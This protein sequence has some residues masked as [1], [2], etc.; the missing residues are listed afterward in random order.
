MSTTHLPEQYTN[1]AHEAGVDGGWSGHLRIVVGKGLGPEELVFVDSDLLGARRLVLTVTE[2]L[3]VAEA[4][5]AAAAEVIPPYPWELR[6]F[7]STFGYP[8]PREHT[9]TTADLKRHVRALSDAH[10][11]ECLSA[12][13]STPK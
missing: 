6:A 9:R 10:E 8:A 12:V 2:A 1:I 13:E 7:Q 3:A 5:E 4:L 11:A